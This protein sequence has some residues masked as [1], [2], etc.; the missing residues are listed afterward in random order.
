VSIVKEIVALHHG[1]L[2]VDSTMGK[3]TE[4]RVFLPLASS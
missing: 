3:G 4:V 1:A 2:E